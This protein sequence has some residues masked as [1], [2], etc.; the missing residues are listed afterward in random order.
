MK[1]RSKDIVPDIL[2]DILPDIVPAIEIS[3]LSKHFRSS[4]IAL[5]SVDFDVDHGEMVALIGPSGS[6]KSTLLRHLSGFGS[7]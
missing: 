7:V 2:P 6:G 3:N 5:E 1:D 4:R